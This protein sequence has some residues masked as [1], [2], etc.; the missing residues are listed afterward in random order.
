MTL[1]VVECCRKCTKPL[2]L[3]LQCASIDAH[4]AREKV[5]LL[6][7]TINE[8]RHGVEQTHAW[9]YEVAVALAEETNITPSKP[10]MA[11]RQV[12]HEN[13][14]AESI[15]EYFRRV[16]TIPFLDQLLGQ[17]QSRF[18]EGNL[19]I[20][21]ASYAMPDIVVSQ[22]DWNEHFSRFLNPRLLLSLEK[23]YF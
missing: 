10:R 23:N 8:L 21:D 1:V 9:F 12:H 16:V 18:S 11:G 14:P 22:S 2:T 17:M 19:D 15:S 20:F 13:V 3:Q 4:K 7:L 6:F 5:C